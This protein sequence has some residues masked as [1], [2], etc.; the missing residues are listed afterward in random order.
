MSQEHDAPDAGA[1]SIP[2]IPAIAKQAPG[3]KDARQAPEGPTLQTG[4]IIGGKFLVN[5]YLGSSDG[6]TSYLCRDQSRD[7]EVV[8]KLIPATLLDQ[9]KQQ[10]LAE[11]VKLSAKLGSHRNLTG[12]YGMGQAPGNQIFV[13]QEFV[14]GYSLS[15]LVATRR[16]KRQRL[17]MRDVFTVI[18][19]LCH[20]LEVV[21]KYMAH[22]VLTPY[23]VYVNRK[24]V[25]KLTNLAFGHAAAMMLH[26]EGKGPY[27]DSIYIAPELVR[28]PMSLSPAADIYSM[29]MIA[30]D[31][32]KAE[33]LPAD[34]DMAKRAISS[35]MAE[36]PA[37]LTQL[38]YAALDQDPEKRPSLLEFHQVFE[39]TARA[40]GATL[41][42]PPKEDELPIEPAVAPETVAQVAAA[43]KANQPAKDEDEDLFNIPELT[44]PDR[45]TSF[46]I[47]KEEEEEEGRY[48]VQKNG[49][50]Y[51]PFTVDQVLEQLRRDE[52]DERTQVLDRLTQDR[53]A[54]IEVPAFTVAVKEYIP[55]REERRRK[56]AEARA[57]LQ[58]KVK[59]GGLAVFY[60][61]IVAGLFVLAGMIYVLVNQPDPEPIPM[62]KAF[63]SLDY[64]LL[65]PPKD[66]KT[67]AVDGALMKSIFDPK[68]SEEEIASKLKSFKKKRKPSNGKVA[69]SG[70]PGEDDEN[71][72]EVDMTGGSKDGRILSDGEINEV[73]M[74][75]FGS[76]RRCI[77]KELQSNPGFKR[78]T[79][80]FFIRPS[81]TTGG[82]K[83]QEG[84]YSGKEVGRCLVD[85][86]RQMKF[87]AHSGF[88]RGVTFP[89]QVQ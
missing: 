39:E 74:G 43:Q 5:R 47:F 17:N 48:L 31:L 82:V 84:A 61:G 6:A 45:S 22:G 70:R 11:G 79:V 64:K 38:L 36:Y 66:F 58:R 49:L 34:R 33:G 27:H 37:R 73:I 4:D 83:I 10:S 77:V 29:A 32:L 28:D 12:V 46:G 23:N 85:R 76:L 72:T 50:D 59:K 80:Q 71:V 53:V 52:I 18:A 7:R 86:F 1:K 56:E 44:S 13:A 16:E 65:P 42:Q 60:V 89:I 41:G 78:V 88:N 69:S 9:S 57:E 55:V 40:Q 51:G 3:V 19:H 81:G 67:V 15:R 35:V 14:D 63:A 21:H 24:G 75:N 68:A 54:L 25:L 2:P 20:V 8:I 30:I 87:P 62:D 26:P